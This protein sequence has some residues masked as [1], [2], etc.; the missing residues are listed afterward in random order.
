MKTRNEIL[1][2]NQ[3]YCESK[4][5]DLKKALNYINLADAINVMPL[6]NIGIKDFNIFV[7]KKKAGILACFDYIFNAKGKLLR[8]VT[9]EVT[10]FGEKLPRS[11]WNIV[12]IFIQ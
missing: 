4:S 9:R 6:T 10:N 1:A 5:F 7:V 3:E 11:K 12:N 2:E 8:V